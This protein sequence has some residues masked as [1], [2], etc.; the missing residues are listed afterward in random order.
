VTPRVPYHV[1]FVVPDLAEGM[2]QFGAALG[3]SWRQAAETDLPVR[4]GAGEHTVRLRYAYS[5]EGPPYLELIECAE[6]TVWA[7]DAGG[8]GVAHHLGYWSDDLAGDAARLEGAGWARELTDAAEG[9][10]CRVLAYHR[11]PA[12]PRVEHV[13]TSMRGLILGS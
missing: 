10:G 12:G 5:V 6:G 13:A 3:V 9:G 2:A 7:C 1:G 11:A 8:A 4:T